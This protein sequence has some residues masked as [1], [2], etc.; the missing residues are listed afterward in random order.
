MPRKTKDRY[1]QLNENFQKYLQRNFKGFKGENTK[2]QL[3]IVEMILTAPTKYR[4]HAVQG[5]RFGYKELE[6][7]FGRKG[8]EA[9]NGRLGLFHISKDEFGRDAWS[10]EKSITKSYLLTDKVSDLREKWLKRGHYRTTNLLTEDGDVIRNMPSQAVNAK[11]ITFTGIEVTRVG[12]NEATVNPAVPV[13]SNKLKLLALQ[14]GKIQYSQEY[15][16]FQGALFHPNPAPHYLE[17]LLFTVRLYLSYA[18]N[19]VHQGYIIHRY[20]QSPSG[21]L[22][23][24]FPSLQNVPRPVRQAALHGLYDYDIENCHYAI[25]AQMAE[26]YGYVCIAIKHYLGNK[27]Q[28]RQQLA[29]EFGINIRQV[30]EVLIALIYGARL[31]LRPEDALPEILGDPEL[32]KRFYAHPLFSALNTDIKSARS[33][34]L[35]AQD[36][37]RQT[38]KNIR[39]MPAKVVDENGQ[40]TSG[41]K[42][43]AHLLQGV[44]SLALECAHKLH[45]DCIVLLQHD[46]WTST[47]QLDTKAIENAIFVGT[48]YRLEVVGEV[49]DCRLDEAMSDHPDEAINPNQKLTHF[50]LKTP[51][52]GSIHAS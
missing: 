43:L 44:E 25:L 18:N 6:Q 37:S 45:S 46:G 7:M 21:R 17:N 23:G 2:T 40:Q 39:G 24:G 1:K 3:A 20:S 4:V 48:G 8:F 9:V 31:S 29:N 13:N 14:I 51:V 30:K 38:I 27:K 28:V 41:S 34:I 5:A 11:R 19:S 26:K 22:Y 42:L 52:L 10:F 16:F 32:I 33:T 49:I 36:I 12:W 15:G 35:Q 47:K 50:P